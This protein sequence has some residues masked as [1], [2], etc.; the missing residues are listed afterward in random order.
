MRAICVP[1]LTAGVWQPDAQTKKTCVTVQQQLLTNLE[2]MHQCT[3]ERKDGLSLCLLRLLDDL[4]WHWW[5]VSLE[6]LG[7]ARQ[8]NWSEADHQVRAQAIS[9][10]CGQSNSKFTAEAIFSH[11]QHVVARSQKGCCVMNKSLPQF[12]PAS[13]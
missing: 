6:S 11:L 7:A 13:A 1:Y 3:V 2:A 4:Q 10:H 8:G 12:L 5:Q 9:L